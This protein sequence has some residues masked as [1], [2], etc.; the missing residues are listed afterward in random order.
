MTGRSVGGLLG[1]RGSRTQMEE[2]IMT[3]KS[4]P[5]A[6]VEAFMANEASSNELASK[7][8]LAYMVGQFPRSCSPQRC[9][10]AARPAG[11]P[12]APAGARREAG[13]TTSLDR[14]AGGRGTPA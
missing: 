4:A 6:S 11:D 7:L 9:L 5:T 1:A 10:A 14:T 8:E 12:N 3:T 13:E 2:I